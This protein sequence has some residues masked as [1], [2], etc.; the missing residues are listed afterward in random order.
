M[1]ERPLR[2]SNAVIQALPA[3]EVA[4]VQKEAFFQRAAMSKRK[5]SSNGGA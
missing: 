4:Q 5:I 2:H 1:L 3:C